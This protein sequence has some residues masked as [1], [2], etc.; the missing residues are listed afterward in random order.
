MF[1][2]IEYQKNK[3]CV[4]NVTHSITKRVGTSKDQTIYRKIAKKKFQSNLANVRL[5][6]SKNWHYMKL[7]QTL[8][9]IGGKRLVLIQY[10][11]TIKS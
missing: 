3:S 5:V 2:K 6:W 4:K 9:W 1:I 8:F 7:N 10:F 11:K